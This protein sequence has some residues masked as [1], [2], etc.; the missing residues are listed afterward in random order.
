MGGVAKS[1]FETLA[2]QSPEAERSTLLYGD[3]VAVKFSWNDSR[4]QCTA[5]LKLRY[6]QNSAQP[7]VHLVGN[8]VSFGFNSNT[9]KFTAA[10]IERF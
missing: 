10:G 7:N 3:L 5:S 1:A 4:N 8:V 9:Q 2:K 6:A